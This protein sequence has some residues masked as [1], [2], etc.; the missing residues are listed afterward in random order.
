MDSPPVA[1][2]SPVQT[3]AFALAGCMAIDV[4]V[5][6]KR[7]RFDLEG[8]RAHLEAE[9]AP[10]DPRRIVRFG[11]TTH[12]SGRFPPTASSARSSSPARSTARSG[13]RCGRTS[14][15]RPAPRHRLSLLHR[16]DGEISNRGAPAT[17]RGRIALIF[18]T[19]IRP[20]PA[21][22]PGHRERGRL[23]D[24][25]VRGVA[26]G[27]GAR[28]LPEP[29][30]RPL[31]PGAAARAPAGSPRS[32]GPAA[33]RPRRCAPRAT[34]CGRASAIDGKPASVSSTGRPHRRAA[35]SSGARARSHP[36]SRSTGEGSGRSDRGK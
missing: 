14:S 15:S 7:G 20:G 21:V 25:G 26:E 31:D 6:M 2:P 9:R 27:R 28:P 10:A 1:G 17:G 35:R 29:E 30:E 23:A 24:D 19:E 8:M 13:T 36:A 18:K 34:A 33:T 11:S 12:W 32:S 4:L 3:L 16:T 22:P 5:V